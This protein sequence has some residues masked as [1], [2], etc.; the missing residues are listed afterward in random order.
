MSTATNGSNPV[1][2]PFPHVPVANILG[3]WLIAVAASFLLNGLL[4]HQTYRYFRD[5]PDDRRFLKVWV[6]AVVILQTFVSALILHTAWFYMIQFYW[7]PMHL[8]LSK[9]VWSIDILPITSSI[10][11]LVS[12]MFFIRRLWLLAPKF[13]KFLAAIIFIMNLGNVGCFIALSVKM[14]VAPSLDS[15]S[16]LTGNMKYAWLASVAVAV[17]MAGDIIL[18]LALFYVFR[19]S[20]TG[21]TKTDS[22]LEVM[23]AYAVGTGAVNCVGHILT[24]A[25]SIAYPHNW[26]YGTFFCIDTKLYAIGF[27]VALDSRKLLA[28][29]RFS[30]DPTQYHGFSNWNIESTIP[31]ASMPVPKATSTPTPIELKVV[32]EE[33]VD[34]D[35]DMH[36]KHSPMTM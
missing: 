21:I 19:K 23:I 18:T 2:E 31:R 7:D 26:I 24:V 28:M 33:I 14:F 1:V 3:A 4:F 16:G 27:L 8:F 29:S 11:A 25:F 9:M 20:R 32:T 10:T 6:T 17:Q 13:L 5:Y 36:S 30:N 22:M 35:D 12:Q 15:S 34:D